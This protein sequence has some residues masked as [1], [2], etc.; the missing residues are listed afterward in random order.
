[1]KIAAI[2]VGSNSIHMLIV[3]V[4]PDHSYE[5]IYK[6]KAMVRLGSGAFSR[7]MLTDAAQK[8]ALA[9]LDRFAQVIRRFE[10]DAVLGVATSAVREARNG[11]SFLKRIREETKLKIDR[12]S[13]NEE[14]RLV[15]VAVGGLSPF[16][17]G[18]HLVI[19][20]GGGS[21]ELAFLE[22]QEPHRVESLK[23]GA[24]RL[25]E[26]L[27]L[28]N[29]PGKKGVK[30]LRRAARDHVG[31]ALRRL[32]G[33]SFDGVA[34]TSGSIV[35]LG[36]LAARRI[37]EPP[38][39]GETFAVGRSALQKELYHLASLSLDERRDYMGD[40]GARADIILA[41]GAIL[42]EILDG[43]IVDF[44]RR[45]LETTPDDHVR[46]LA[47][48]AS[49]RRE[50]PFD[51]H[52]V[53][54][55]TIMSFA[56]RYHYEAEHAH[57][58]MRLSAQLFDAT[59]ELH[60]LGAEEKF[61][62]EAA[63]LLHDIGQY[64][65]YSQHHKHS[66]YL[67]MN[68]GLPGF[69][70]RETQIIGNIARYHRRALPSPDHVEHAQLAAEDRRIVDRLSGLL[71]VADALDYGHLSSVERIRVSWKGRRALFHV[72][73]RRECRAEIERAVRKADLFERVFGR[74]AVF[75]SRRLPA[76]SLKRAQVA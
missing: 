32:R 11:V 22:N 52:T 10:T 65:S 6:D 2:D 57:Q 26:S 29:K 36:M 67:I 44:N 13:G 47:R 30:E 53:R 58:V 21:T 23:L 31:A 73:A 37:G 72:T 70:E 28:K 69:L 40:Q 25:A 66:M 35:C 16:N 71:R 34:G 49:T 61:Y 55:R 51:P 19:D 62:L 76:G 5:T 9:A 15:A 56:R 48:M 46:S 17:R 42:L 39:R 68:S 59:M 43:M 14:A 75:K 54:E 33:S 8:K 27:S 38:F 7:G 60:G 50:D 64:I 74:R 12:I 63:A 24:V 45:N 18:R 1:M 41:G 4:L 3:R 20:I